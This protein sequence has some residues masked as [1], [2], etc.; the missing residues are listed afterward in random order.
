[1]RIFDN[2]KEM[3][4]DVKRDLHEMGTIVHPETMQDIDVKDNPDFRTLELSPATF[5]IL[6]GDDRDEWLLSLGGNLE[7]CKADF[8]ERVHSPIYHSCPGPNPGQA[9]ELRRETWAPFIHDGR[10]AYTYGER[11]GAQSEINDSPKTALQRVVEQLSMNTGTRQAVLPIFDGYRDLPNLGGKKRVPCS[12][13]YQFMR[14]RGVLDM[15]YVMRSTDFHT[16][17]MYDT[18]MA[19]NMRDFVAGLLGIEPGRYIYFTASLHIYAKD[20]EEGV[21]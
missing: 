20:A 12:L 15:I 17:F 14:R 8:H 5:M 10:F 19:L 16:H 9:W 3:Y 4:S 21:F 13:H 1:M 18:W 11:F 2:C 6:N 7:W